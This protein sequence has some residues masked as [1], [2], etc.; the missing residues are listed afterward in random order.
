MISEDREA[1]VNS[2][3]RF[4]TAARASQ[5]SGSMQQASGA[6]DRADVRGLRDTDP[7][8]SWTRA[9]RRRQG[10]A[11]RLRAGLHGNSAVLRIFAARRFPIAAAITRICFINPE[12]SEVAEDELCAAVG[13]RYRCHRQ[14]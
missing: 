2:Q 5:V 13:A 3:Q 6:L 9:S 8:G 14:E 12:M 11:W 4:V 1:P 7:A 10:K